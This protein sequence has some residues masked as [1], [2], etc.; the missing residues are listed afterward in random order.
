VVAPIMPCMELRQRQPRN[1][2][3]MTLPEMSAGTRGLTKGFSAGVEGG[4]GT[5]LCSASC[6]VTGGG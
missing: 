2:P 5:Y 6:L 3:C 1:G 4:G